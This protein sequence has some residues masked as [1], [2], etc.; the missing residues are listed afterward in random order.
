MVN[1]GNRVRYPQRPER[2]EFRTQGEG[3]GA[4]GVKSLPLEPGRR[5][6]G[7][8]TVECKGLVGEKLGRPY[9]LITE[10]LENLD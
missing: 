3:F 1:T 6:D 2:M 10:K 8:D 7:Q 5:S 9:M 4:R